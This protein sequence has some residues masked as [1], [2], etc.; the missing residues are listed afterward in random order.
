MS[1]KYLK[2]FNIKLIL[3]IMASHEIEED[4]LEVDKPIP[5]QNYVCLSFVSPEEVLKNK[6][7]F[8]VHKFL[9]TI[10]KKY[11]LD[12]NSIQEQFQDFLYVNEDKLGKIFYEENDFRTTVRGLKVRGVYDTIK[13]AQ[14]R[15]KILQRRDRGFNVFV[16]QVGFW[17]PWDPNPHKIATQEYGNKQLNELIHKYKENQEDKETHFQENIDYVKE[18]AALKAKKVKDEQQ[19]V[20]EEKKQK[21]L[22]EYR[23]GLGIEEL[24]DDNE[25]GNIGAGV[26]EVVQ[27]VVQEQSEQK[28]NTVEETPVNVVPQDIK[29]GLEDND[30]WLQNK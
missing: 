13:E 6:N 9:E 8:F 19:K 15:A 17:L 26:E 7:V 28:V 30:P 14:I 23:K 25:E 21:Q 24:M 20:K 11:D 10:A 2:L 3:L 18:Q 27:E 12:K 16:G 22:E 5:G 29:N 1:N 4:F